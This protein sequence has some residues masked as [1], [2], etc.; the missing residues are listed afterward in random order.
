VGKIVFRAPI[1]IQEFTSEIVFLAGALEDPLA[2]RD[3]FLAD[4]VAGDH[5]NI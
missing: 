3:D 4:T 5:C 1:E 2:L